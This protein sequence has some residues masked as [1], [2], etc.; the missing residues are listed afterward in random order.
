ML[1]QKVELV[2]VPAVP[3][4]GGNVWKIRALSIGGKSPAMHLLS[5]WEKG[6]KQNFKKIIHSLKMAAREKRVTDRKWVAKCANS[7]LGEVYEAIAYTLE[8]RMMFF[9]SEKERAIICTNGCWKPTKD[10][11]TAFKHC[12]DFKQLFDTYYVPKLTSPKKH[13]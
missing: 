7:D 5:E 4:F 3:D 12:A 13:R 8:A 6:E 9:Y 11:G 10:Q 1:T 2:E